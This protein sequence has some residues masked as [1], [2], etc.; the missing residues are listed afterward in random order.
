MKL[1][2]L[3]ILVLILLYQICNIREGLLIPDSAN[4]PMS[5][6]KVE[7]AKSNTKECSDSLHFHGCNIA[8]PSLKQLDMRYVNPASKQIDNSDIYT[9]LSICPM[10]YQDNMIILSNKQSLGQYSGYSPNQY[11]DKIRY[12]D[13][14]IPLPVNP[15]FFVKNGGT[16]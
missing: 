13:S 2:L 14:K 16:Y 12:I 8:S 6:L 11:I 3:S 7:I 5:N 9:H 4:N 15:D 1:L 10:K